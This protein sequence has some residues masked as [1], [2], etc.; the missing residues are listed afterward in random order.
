[1]STS[2]QARRDQSPT[3]RA[4]GTPCDRGWKRTFEHMV[5]FL[6]LGAQAQ[7]VSVE[8][9]SC[10]AGRTATLRTFAPRGVVFEDKG[11]RTY[12]NLTVSR[13]HIGDGRGRLPE[14]RR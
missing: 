2:L 12:A 8:V 4:P 7:T 11:H 3:T 9:Q 6:P 1:M 14:S 13:A 10:A 5:Q